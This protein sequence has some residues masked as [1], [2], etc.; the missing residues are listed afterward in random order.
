MSDRSARE[1]F[2]SCRQS[3]A[4]IADEVIDYLE[5]SLKSSG[6][7]PDS[8]P[9]E[10]L[11]RE[12]AIA[13]MFLELNHRCLN[14][15][16]LAD[17]MP[18]EL[19]TVASI[20]KAAKD[21]E[22][23]T[24]LSRQIIERRAAIGPEVFE[25]FGFNTIGNLLVL[26][27]SRSVDAFSGTD[28]TALDDLHTIECELDDMHRQVHENAK[29]LMQVGMYSPGE[30]LASR[31][32]SWNLERIAAHASGISRSLPLAFDLFPMEPIHI[33]K[34]MPMTGFSKN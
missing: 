33:G 1:Q 2:E 4:L 20:M 13:L 31:S 27:A 28:P 34:M 7:T 21:L 23:V 14:L 26:L 11:S 15:L 16:T 8:F 18:Q 5:S 17:S 12:H 19:Q 3:F 25:S 10:I 24:D 22:Q 29:A 30:I 9:E 6:M 32:L